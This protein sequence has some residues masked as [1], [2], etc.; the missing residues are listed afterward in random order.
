MNSMLNKLLTFNT[1]SYVTC[2]PVA[3][4]W[5]C[6]CVCVCVCECV[7]VG[8]CVCV[9]VCVFECAGKFTHETNSLL[10][11]DRLVEMLKACL[12]VSRKQWSS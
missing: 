8:V 12:S 7:C 3:S 11:E 4:T 2:L 5:E 6:V 10:C 9:C 1:D